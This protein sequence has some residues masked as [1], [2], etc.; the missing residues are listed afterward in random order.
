MSAAPILKALIARG[1][2]GST[3]VGRGLAMPH[4]AVPEIAAPICLFA[5]TAKPV[6][7]EAI[8]G[9]PV[10]LVMLILSGAFQRGQNLNLLSRAA[11]HLRSDEVLSAVRDAKTKEEVFVILT[12]ND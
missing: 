11:R 8:D 7:Y 5:R 1:E 9:E 6:A 3:G 2:L 4:A 10:D 12:Q